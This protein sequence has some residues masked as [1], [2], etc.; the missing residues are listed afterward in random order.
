MKNTLK[1]LVAIA[2]LA[3]FSLVAQAQPTAQQQD[4]VR[5]SC[6]S[7]YMANCAS[8]PRGGAASLQC[9]QNNVAKLS[10]PCKA[11]VSAI[12]KK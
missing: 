11:A 5:K 1:S 4:A 9:L 8:V 12:E 6:R 10:P 2:A 3:G 7:G